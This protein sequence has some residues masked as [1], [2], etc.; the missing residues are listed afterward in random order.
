MP[1]SLTNKRPPLKF[2]KA[3]APNHTKLSALCIAQ[4]EHCGFPANTLTLSIVPSDISGIISETP[5]L[6]QKYALLRP[7]ALA[8]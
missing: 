8:V 3:V 1:L 6:F 5:L 4:I 2:R 7:T